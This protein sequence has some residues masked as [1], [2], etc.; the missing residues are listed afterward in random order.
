MLVS[1]VIP[2]LNEEGNAREL[3]KRLEAALAPIS[4]CS[5][6]IV[7]VDDGST[8]STLDVFK[9]LPEIKNT[10]LK[11][12]ELSRNFG[13]QVAISAGMEQATGEA[14]LF[15]D[16]DLQ[17]PPEM[18]TAFITKFREGY[19]VVYAVRKTRQEG[20]VT[21]TC[22]KLFYRIFNSIAERPMP[23]DSGDFS[24][25]SRRVAN[26]LI[27]MPE[28]DRLVRGMRSWVGFRQI[29]LEYDR[30]GR[31]SGTTRYGFRKHLELA[32]DGLFSFTRVP[33]RF[34]MML[35]VAVMAIG[36][37]YLIR[38]YVV[39]YILGDPTPPGWTSLVTLGFMTAGA[40]ILVTAIVGEYVCRIYFQGKQRPLFIIKE[41][42]ERK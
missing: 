24:L 5:F 34:S 10:S 33:I 26:I 6:E 35:G 3:W 42:W 18:I 38:S 25:I 32:F 31:H 23:L 16:A 15:L 2:V 22:F 14:I 12:V 13:H 1:L 19:E 36:G 4:D 17:D 30:P 21:Q 39:R 7:I 28:R 20:W 41:I 27:K 29:G 8:D 37:I 11:L 9:S 40:N